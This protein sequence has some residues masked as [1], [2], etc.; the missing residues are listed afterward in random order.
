MNEHHELIDKLRE[1]GDTI[2]IYDKIVDQTIKKLRSKNCGSKGLV[3]I[4][5]PES[6]S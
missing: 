6:Y 3:P 4:N 1:H 5:Q 2:A